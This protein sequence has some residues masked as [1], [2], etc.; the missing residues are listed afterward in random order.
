MKRA[1]YWKFGKYHEKQ[2]GEASYTFVLPKSKKSIRDIDMSPELRKEL[3]Q[4][5]MKTGK[6]GLVFS[7]PTGEPMHPDNFVKRNFKAV[8]EKAEARRR[9]NNLPPIGHVRWHDLRHTFGSLKIDQ[10]EDI[11]YVSRQMGH[12]S[13]S[14]T[15]DV[16]AHELRKRRPEAAAKTDAMIF[17]MN[18]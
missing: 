4:L 17:G 3:L 5:Y 16:Y 10:G 2:E 1:L 7:G 18:S 12:A 8:L 15:A 14:I 9:E 6:R 11:V 13:V